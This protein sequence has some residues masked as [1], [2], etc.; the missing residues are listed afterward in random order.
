MPLQ[1][2]ARNLARYAAGEARFGAYGVFET[3]DGAVVRHFSDERFAAMLTG[4]EEIDR[5]AI[6]LH[7]MNG[8]AAS[9]VQM[10][11]RRPV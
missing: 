1:T 7:T 9:G 2:D 4:F 6:A 8:N 5:R 3:D 10:L 11:L